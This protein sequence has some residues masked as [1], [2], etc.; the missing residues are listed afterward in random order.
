MA[1]ANGGD[2]MKR[3]LSFEKDAPEPRAAEPTEQGRVVVLSQVGDFTTAT[4]GARRK[5]CS[6]AVSPSCAM[7][8]PDGEFVYHRALT[9]GAPRPDGRPPVVS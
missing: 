3:T 9:L 6:R 7:V 5:A 8:L 2:I 4:C 1:G